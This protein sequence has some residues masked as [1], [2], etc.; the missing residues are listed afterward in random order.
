VV[1]EKVAIKEISGE[2]NLSFETPACQDMS[3]GD[4]GVGSWRLMVRKEL[5]CEKKTSCVI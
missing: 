1:P 4:F 5:L 2:K 3:L